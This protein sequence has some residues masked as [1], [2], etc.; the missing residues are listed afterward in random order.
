MYLAYFDESG[1][2]GSSFDPQKPYQVLAGIIMDCHRIHRTTGIMEYLVSTIKN[3]NAQFTEFKAD[4]FYNRRGAWEKLVPD[5]TKRHELFWDFLAMIKRRKHQIFLSVIDQKK[6]FECIKTEEFKEIG[7]VLHCPY[8]AA[9]FHAG[10]SIQKYHQ[11][12]KRMKGLTVLIFDEQVKYQNELQKIY[13]NP[14]EWG[15]EFYN[16]KKTD[17]PFTQILDPPYFG[18]SH[19]VFPI[20]IADMYAFVCRKYVEL[21]YGNFSEKYDGEKEKITDFFSFIKS[22]LIPKNQTL[23]EKGNAKILNFYRSFS[24]RI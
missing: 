5:G 12:K 13:S 22:R 20:Q 10:L 19:L 21:K 7:S 11:T 6:Y 4:D 23:P 9:A 16:E 18:K 1:Y 2:S 24:I 17:K 3:M 14:P 8:L 15:N